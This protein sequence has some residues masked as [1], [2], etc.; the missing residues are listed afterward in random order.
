MTPANRLDVREYDAVL[1]LCAAPGGKATELGV[2]LAGKG[3]LVANDISTSRTRALLRNIELSGI[4]NVFVA[5]EAP[6]KLV[7]SF[8]EFFHKKGT[9]LPTGSF[10]SCVYNILECVNTNNII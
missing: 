10:L 3:V 7:K 1:D 2:K 5:N 4:P 8:P 6:A 9:C